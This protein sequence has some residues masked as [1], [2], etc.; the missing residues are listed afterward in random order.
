MALTL[1]TG[2]LSVL[3]FLSLVGFMFITVGYCLL[4]SII[5]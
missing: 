1:R 5:D 3:G 4:V 2:V